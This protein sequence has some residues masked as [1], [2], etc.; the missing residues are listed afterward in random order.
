MLCS[1]DFISDL[2]FLDYYE[3]VKGGRPG[4]Y[5]ILSYNFLS[6]VI[7]LLVFILVSLLSVY[8]RIYIYL[9]ELGTSMIHHGL[10]NYEKW[11]M[12]MNKR[13]SISRSS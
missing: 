3:I 11:K 12:K 13:D 1:V 5:L 9:I 7:T 10:W 4:C 8:S 6:I 2:F